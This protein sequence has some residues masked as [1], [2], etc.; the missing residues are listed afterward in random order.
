MS[1]F[2]TAV[3]AAIAAALVA[4][5]GGAARADAAAQETIQAACE[6]EL[7]VPP[8]VCPCLAAK[9]G[10]DLDD[11]QQAWLAA[12]MTKQMNEALA[13][14]DQ[15]SPT[16]AMQAGMFLVGGVPACAG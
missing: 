6:T 15:M 12:S 10:A 16:Q 9:A 5:P 13:L 8:G 1:S 4:A 3:A 7:D 14:K 11:L 2:A